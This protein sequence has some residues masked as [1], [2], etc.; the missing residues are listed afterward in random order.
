MVNCCNS[1]T[2]KKK[3]LFFVLAMCLT[4]VFYM[5]CGDDNENVDSNISSILQSSKWYNKDTDYNT[6]SDQMSEDISMTTLYFRSGN[7]G[8]GCNILKTNDSYFGTSSNEEWWTF[9]YYVSGN[10]VTVSNGKKSVIYTYSNGILI[11]TDGMMYVRMDYTSSDYTAI[12]KQETTNKW[13]DVEKNINNY[14]S[15]QYTLRNYAQYEVEIKSTLSNVLSGEYIKYGAECDFDGNGTYEYS[16]Y[17]KE[18]G[19]NT[20]TITAISSTNSM[21]LESYINIKKKLAN[22]EKIDPSEYSMMSSVET[23]FAKTKK[24]FK[25]RVFVE[26]GGTKHYIDNFRSSNCTEVID[27]EYLIN[28]GNGN[29]NEEQIPTTG[30]SNGHEWVD[31]GLSVKWATCN[32][33]ASKPEEYGEYYAWGETTTK[34]D[35]YFDNNKWYDQINKLYTKY[36]STDNKLELEKSD[37]VAYMKWGKQWRIPS[38]EQVEE[39]LQQCDWILTT[40]NGVSG[41]EVKSKTT[42]GVIFLPLAG[43]RITWFLEEG[44]GDYHTRTIRDKYDFKFFYD[45]LLRSDRYILNDGG[46]R[47]NGHT[48][49]PVF[50]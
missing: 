46:D 34:N 24:N 10:Q 35:F 20:Y 40:K 4:S 8:Y 7:K 44:F 12:S 11:S 6:W 43:V 49:R 42:K 13:N 17:A 30:K 25:G 37:D 31:L 23:E 3:S 28:N 32:V 14:V 36:N 21:F 39:L 5:S 45:L 50:E 2:M 27:N 29:G 47:R 19:Y 16:F 18:S 15:C 33:G 22:G 26:M 1:L 41:Y 38:R 9:S 48:V